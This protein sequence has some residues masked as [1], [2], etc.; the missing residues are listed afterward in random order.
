MPKAVVGD[1]DG[2][3]HLC[4][5]L[6]FEIARRHEHSTTIHQMLCIQFKGAVLQFL[7]SRAQLG[8]EEIRR[9]A[10]EYARRVERH[11]ASPL[12]SVV[13]SED[14]AFKS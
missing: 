6:A 13:N 3:T 7:R 2:K 9:V 14:I 10:T 5:N 4:Q 1:Y 8:T 11:E 12:E